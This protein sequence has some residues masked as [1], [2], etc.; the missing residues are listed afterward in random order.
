MGYDFT[1]WVHFLL[2]KLFPVHGTEQKFS[3]AWSAPKNSVT[4]VF[5]NGMRMEMVAKRR[6]GPQK[7]WEAPN[8]GFISDT[9]FTPSKV[10]RSW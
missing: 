10:V 9:P 2:V 5:G 1:V 4:S 3:V 6:W 8:S 7:G